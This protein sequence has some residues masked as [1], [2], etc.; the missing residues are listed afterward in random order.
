MRLQRDLVCNQ[1]PNQKIGFLNYSLSL[2]VFNFFLFVKSLMEISL[3]L[4][5]GFF[6]R[7]YKHFVVKLYPPFVYVSVVK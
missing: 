7:I 5:G 1:V 3:F 2:F 4:P 6:V